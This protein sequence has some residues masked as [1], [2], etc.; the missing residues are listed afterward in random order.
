MTLLRIDGFFNNSPT[1]ST[2]RLA[3]IMSLKRI[4]ATSER[5]RI[6]ITIPMDVAGAPSILDIIEALETIFKP[7]L[8]DSDYSL[9]SAFGQIFFFFYGIQE[10]IELEEQKCR[11]EMSLCRARDPLHLRTLLLSRVIQCLLNE[12]FAISTCQERFKR[13]Y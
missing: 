8:P 9:P 10:Q 3:A 12:D 13:Q 7:A 4:V 1:A 5:A 11:R 2:L 6:A